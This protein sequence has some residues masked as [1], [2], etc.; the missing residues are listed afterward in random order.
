MSWKLIS[1]S[2]EREDERDDFEDVPDFTT[3]NAQSVPYRGY[4]SV[5]VVFS[6][7]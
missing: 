5:K 6:D 2:V 3:R 7:G 4:S 1:A